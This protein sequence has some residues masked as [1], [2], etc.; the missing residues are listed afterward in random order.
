MQ[1]TCSLLDLELD[2]HTM[3]WACWTCVVEH[4]DI[5]CWTWA[6]EHVD[7]SGCKWSFWITQ[8]PCTYKS[9]CRWTLQ[10][11]SFTPSQLAIPFS[12]SSSVSVSLSH[13]TRRRSPSLGSHCH[14]FPPPSPLLPPLSYL[15]LSPS[16]PLCLPL[17]FLILNQHDWSLLGL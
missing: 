6:V 15:C 14:S 7:V 9:Y 8:E 2:S 1:R 4:V 10:L 16:L 11:L 12:S 5:V 17:W 3:C 13:R